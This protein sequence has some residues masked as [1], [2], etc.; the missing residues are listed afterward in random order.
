MNRPRSVTSVAVPLGITLSTGKSNSTNA[1]PATG[2]DETQRP[3]LPRGRNEL[4]L[5]VDDE[6]AIRD[7]ARQILERFGYRV[8]LAV[9]GAEAVSIYASR[10]KEIAV[11][12]TDMI[13]PNMEG[14]AAIIA[15]RAINPEVKII[16]SSGAASDR[17]MA[18]VRD[19]GIRHYIAKPY[20]AE[21][22]LNT[23]HEVLHGSP[24]K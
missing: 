2:P 6:P 13:M 23:L 14:S 17:S 8:L 5:V 10:Q 16:A 22:M 4:V 7:V 21:V 11:V 12:I 24:A 1:A 3:K 9:D 19:T 15:L 20:T 18:R